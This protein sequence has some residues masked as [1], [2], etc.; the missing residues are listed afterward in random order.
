MKSIIKLTKTIFMPGVGEG[1]G[2]GGVRDG[3][4]VCLIKVSGEAR[5]DVV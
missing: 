2:K 5:D 3:G 1:G 4:S